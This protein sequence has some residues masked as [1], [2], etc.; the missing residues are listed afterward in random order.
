M[1]GQQL[2]GAVVLAMVVYA[3]AVEGGCRGGV[4]LLG[5]VEDP[6][7]DRRCQDG[8]V[9]SD[10]WQHALRRWRHQR[11]GADGGTATAAR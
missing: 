3:A 5:P 11:S 7:I 6:R 2:L 10:S 4:R 9:R 1:V 8:T